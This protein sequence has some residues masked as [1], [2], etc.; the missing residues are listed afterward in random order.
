MEHATRLH[1]T[2]V[3]FDA[4]CHMQYELLNYL[5]PENERLSPKKGSFQKEF[6]SSNQHFSG[7]VLN[8]FEKKHPK[9][10]LVDGWTTYYVEKYARKIKK[11]FP[12]NFGDNKK[13]P[14]K[15]QKMKTQPQGGPLPVVN[16]VI[17][18]INDLVNL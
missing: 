7:A 14:T 3:L 2:F 16:G 4:S 17:T 15:K 18:P 5:P 11:H 1:Q 12:K 13:C 9:H 8:L 6:S 10:P